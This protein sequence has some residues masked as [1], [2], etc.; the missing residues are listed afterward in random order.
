MTELASADPTAIVRTEAAGGMTETASADPTALVRAEEAAVA[1][2]DASETPADGCIGGKAGGNGETVP[3]ATEEVESGAANAGDGEGSSK[4]TPPPSPP[5]PPPVDLEE[6]DLSLSRAL[7]NRNFSNFSAWHLRALLQQTTAGGSANRVTVTEELEWLQ[8][9]IYT[10]PNDQSLWLYHHWLTILDRGGNEEARITHTALLQGDIYVFFSRAV[11]CCGG[12]DGVV[13][14]VRSASE[15]TA[16]PVEGDLVPLGTTAPRPTKAG[17]SRLRWSH[18]WRFVP[19]SGKV[20][21]TAVELEFVAGVL[22]VGTDACGNKA[23]G[24]RRLVFQGPPV[25]CDSE[26]PGTL[27]PAVASLVTP[28]PMAPERTDMLKKELDRVEELLELE[29]DC[30]FALLAKGR[31]A[32]A[33]AAPA[34]LRSAEDAAVE[35]YRRIADLDPLRRGFYEEACATCAQRSRVLAWLVAADGGS[36]T[37]DVGNGSDGGGSSD[38]DGGGGAGSG[39][40]GK[41]S[42][43]DLSGIG[44]HHPA[45]PVTLAA[46]GVRRLDISGNA[47]V[48]FGPI[49]A[50]ASLEELCVARN[51]IIGSVAE[52]FVL[53]WLRRLDV[54]GNRLVLSGDVAGQAPTTLNEVDLSNNPGI[55]ALAGGHVDGAMVAGEG[56][57]DAG[58]AGMR[59]LDQFLAGMGA[60]DRPPWNVELALASGRCVC[61][62]NTA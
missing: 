12:A 8:Q 35:G 43:L 59:V 18:A 58:A 53:P 39:G 34:A 36:S 42:L 62:R 56:D 47:L 9:G 61:H 23:D 57:C 22:A 50:L 26:A 11:C 37:A 32:I 48:T 44:L 41:L 15:V 17:A 1:D 14:S 4:V 60:E 52:A 3:A 10:E 54:S 40:S 51:M 6:L 7:I 28:E 24:L 20:P 46:F 21:D 19:R 16:S 27:R 31:L 5:R 13:P 49:L 25:R 2:V 55:L 29:P 38:A 30:K 33:H 45:P